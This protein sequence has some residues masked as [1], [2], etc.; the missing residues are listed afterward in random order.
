MV[1]DKYAFYS[2]KLPDSYAWVVR[3]E[4]SADFVCFNY[5]EFVLFKEFFDVSDKVFPLITVRS[6]LFKDGKAYYKKVKIFSEDVTASFVAG[7]YILYDG[8]YVV[9]V[10]FGG[11]KGCLFLN[12]SKKTFLG[13]YSREL[14]GISSPRVAR[15]MLV[16]S[17]YIDFDNLF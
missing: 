14:G 6:I 1:I 7:R 9:S 13:S 3:P 2:K 4:L 16:L 8:V 10:A 12:K 11:A 17:Q 15:I 5:D